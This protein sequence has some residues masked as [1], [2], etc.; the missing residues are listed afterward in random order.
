MDYFEKITSKLSNN[1]S[2]MSLQNSSLNINEH[3]NINSE[4]S[5]EIIGYLEKLIKIFERTQAGENPKSYFIKNEGLT[6]IE[7]L[8]TEVS[9]DSN[10]IACLLLKV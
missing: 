5:S 6:L 3:S 8:F 2:S 7:I 4:E 10:E 9:W 1:G